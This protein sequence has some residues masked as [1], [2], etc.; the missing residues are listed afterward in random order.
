MSGPL[1]LW[2]A[3]PGRVAAWVAALLAFA[4]PL[5]GTA[6]TA[7][8]ADRSL[9]AG[10]A[11]TQER[12]DFGTTTTSTL[13]ELAV[14]LRYGFKRG[15]VRVTVPYLW[16]EDRDATGATTRAQGLGNVYVAGRV[17]L[18]E[19]RGQRPALSV[20]GEVKLPTA[21]ESAGLGSG[22]ADF[23]AGLGLDAFVT[24]DAFWFADA[25]YTVIGHAANDPVLNPWRLTVGGGSYLPAQFVVSAA[26]E[27]R[28]AV[29]AG[30]PV[31]REALLAVSQ[32]STRG[33]RLAL[34]KGLTDGAPAVGITVGAFADF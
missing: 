10:L 12:G 21:S 20:I 9:Q 3:K 19:Q 5:L 4:L 22:Y 17:W 13:R 33:W 23:T 27:Q 18:S 26:L 24:R 14:A 34:S 30:D 2:L 28:G 31:A 15:N 8:A 29:Y 32:G 16:V 1:A 6:R 25:A 11:Y 7:S